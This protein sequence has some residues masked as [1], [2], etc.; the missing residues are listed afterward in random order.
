MM[1]YF[2]ASQAVPKQHDD[3]RAHDDGEGQLRVL[4]PRLAEGHDAVRD[5]FD[6]GH[7][8]AAVG[9]GLEQQPHAEVADHGRRQR[10]RHGA[11]RHGMACR[12][13]RLWKTP[14]P[15]VAS[16]V[17]TKRNVGTMNAAPVS[18]TPRMLT[19]ARN[20]RPRG[21]AAACAVPA[22]AGRRRRRRR[23]R[24]CPPPR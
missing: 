13:A 24:K 16:N 1:P 23:R 14:T 18:L 5:G 8:G 22:R 19:M 3:Q 9:E 20:A 7:G 2:L 6:A 11:T 15:T 21:R 17:P 12:H 10:M 4:H